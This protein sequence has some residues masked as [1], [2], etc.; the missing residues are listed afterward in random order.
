MRLN[1][2]VLN[3][4]KHGGR[5]EPEQRPLALTLTTDRRALARS[6]DAVSGEGGGGGEDLGGVVLELNRF[7]NS[8]G[9]VAADGASAPAE[10]GGRSW[11]TMLR[12]KARSRTTAMPVSAHAPN[13][14]PRFAHA[15][16]KSFAHSLRHVA[17]LVVDLPR[18]RAQNEV[19]DRGPCQR[20]SR[21]LAKRM[22]L[23]S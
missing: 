13:A 12:V 23:Q 6:Y 21:R 14:Q 4:N 8:D 11:D 19:T 18:R 2:A 15:S 16:L 3:R 9:R 7:S 5:E 17:H 22:R 1:N 10:I 20:T